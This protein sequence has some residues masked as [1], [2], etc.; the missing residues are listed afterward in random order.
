[1]TKTQEHYSILIRN[2]TSNTWHA[3]YGNMVELGLARALDLARKFEIPFLALIL[4]LPDGTVRSRGTWRG[5]TVNKD[6]SFDFSPVRPHGCGRAVRLCG[7]AGIGRM[8]PETLS[9]KREVAR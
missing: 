2:K 6:C 4:I 7:R 5:R 1:M 9:G 8:Y 3:Q